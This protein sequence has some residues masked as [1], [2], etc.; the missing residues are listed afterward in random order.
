MPLPELPPAAAPYVCRDRFGGADV[1]VASGRLDRPGGALRVTEEEAAAAGECPFCVG[2]E[3]R[4]PPTVMQW[5]PE[6]AGHWHLR[7]F[8]NKYP[9][10][11]AAGPA[12]GV[13]EVLV[14]RP[15]HDSRWADLSDEHVAVFFRLLHDRTGQLRRPGIEHVTVFKNRGRVAGASQPHG[16]AQLL[17]AAFVPPTVRGLV[18]RSRSDDGFWRR[19]LAEELA[20][21]RRH[22]GRFGPVTAWCPEAS[23]FP[24]EVWLAAPQGQPWGEACGDLGVALRSVVAALEGWLPEVAYNWILLLPPTAAPDAFGWHL[25]LT[26]RLTGLA[27]FEIGA[28]MHINPLPPEWCAHRYRGALPRP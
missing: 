6:G 14:E 24:L 18:Q 27:G 22:V 17:A 7:L 20:D 9:A 8:A 13:H 26:P 10:V 1:L 21:D 2:H 16:H 4:T 5:R 19:T 12:P 25:R 28:G 15:D 3:D 11:T 23:R